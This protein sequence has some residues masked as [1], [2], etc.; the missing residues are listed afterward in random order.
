LSDKRGAGKNIIEW[1]TETPESENVEFSTS[2][3]KGPPCT[4]LTR[5]SS[6]ADVG[7]KL[8]AAICY[9]IWVRVDGQD[10]LDPANLPGQIG[11]LVDG[12]CQHH[13]K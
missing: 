3:Y 12:V 1:T 9:Q 2:D 13:W 7:G 6:M 10:C 4:G 5:V 8:Y 11:V